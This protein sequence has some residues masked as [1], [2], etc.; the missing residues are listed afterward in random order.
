MIA[1]QLKFELYLMGIVNYSSSNSD[2]NRI[3]VDNY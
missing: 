2:R 3:L 1:L